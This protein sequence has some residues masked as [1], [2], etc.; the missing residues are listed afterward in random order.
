[1]ASA[2]SSPHLLCQPLSQLDLIIFAHSS[3]VRR[4]EPIQSY[5]KVNTSQSEFN[6]EIRLVKKNLVGIKNFCEVVHVRGRIAT[7]WT[8]QDIAGLR[9][10]TSI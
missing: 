6:T 9:L 10:A 4:T 5:H 7:P 8:I 1:M 2:N 3:A